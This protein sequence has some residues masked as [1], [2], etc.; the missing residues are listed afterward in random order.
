MRTQLLQAHKMRALSTMAEGMGHELNNILAPLQ[1]YSEMGLSGMMAPET[2]FSKIL[3]G[4]KRAREL[5]MKLIMTSRPPTEASETLD[6]KDFVERHVPILSESAPEGISVSWSVPDRP[7]IVQLTTEHAR[8]VLL[9]LWSNAIWAV[10]PGGHIDISLQEVRVDPS[11]A[12]LN[13]NLSEGSYAVLS[14]RDD[15][16]GMDEVTKARAPEPFFSSRV[17][18]GSGLGL[19][20]VHGLITHHH[21][22]VVIESTP[23][24]GTT[25]QAYIPI[26]G[27]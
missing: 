12:A 21:G 2:C 19:S 11:Q 7:I 6:L 27:Q 24:E 14:V 15:G 17:P 13:P 20:V 3:D 1:G 8:Q 25:V 18:L 26:C 16:C 22:T 5:T 9:H 4:V 10:S 23:N